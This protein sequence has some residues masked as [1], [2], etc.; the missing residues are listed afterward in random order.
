MEF[1]GAAEQSTRANRLLFLTQ[2][3]DVGGTVR[4]H[5]QTK[6]HVE[7]ARR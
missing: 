1:V 7:E 4:F 5:P 3:G 6:S 2:V